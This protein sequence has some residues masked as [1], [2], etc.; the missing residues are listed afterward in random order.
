MDSV[1]ICISR[2][3]KTLDMVEFMLDEMNAADSKIHSMDCIYT[4]IHFGKQ[5]LVR[6]D[7]YL[8]EIQKHVTIDS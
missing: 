7:E 4:L 5:E 2:L 8:S 1:E 3:G 6:L